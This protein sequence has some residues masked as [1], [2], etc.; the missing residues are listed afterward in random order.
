MGS[1]AVELGSSF[2][3][4]AAVHLSVWLGTV[5]MP[6]LA[7][8]LIIVSILQFACGREFTQNLYRALLC[9]LSSALTRALEPCM[10]RSGF[11]NGVVSGLFRVEF[12]GRMAV[13]TLPIYAAYQIA[14]TAFPPRGASRSDPTNRWLR[15]LLAAT[16]CLM[17]PSL[18]WVA[19]SILRHGVGQ[20]W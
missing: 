7:A 19:D 2:F 8:G 18:L 13:V 6:G 12:L 1:G 15:Q 16:L 10:L 17:I 11:G 4:Q 20:G 5:I 14:F 3:Y 9:I